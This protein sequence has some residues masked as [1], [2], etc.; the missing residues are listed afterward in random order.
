MDG[1]P[2]IDDVI[3]RI[4]L[5]RGVDGDV[6]SLSGGNMNAVFLMLRQYID[7]ET[8]TAEALGAPGQITMIVA[9]LRRLHGG[10]RF[11][12]G[13]DMI[14]MAR[15]WLRVCDERGSGPLPAFASAWIS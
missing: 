13:F 12:R 14:Q 4:P 11:L 1:D 10:R 3:G 2:T 8:M 15:S 7:G 5:F 6:S 9:S